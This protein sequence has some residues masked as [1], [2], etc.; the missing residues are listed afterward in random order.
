VNFV[1]YSTL[2]VRIF[3]NHFLTYI[4]LFSSLSICLTGCSDNAKLPSAKELAEFE[5]AGPSNGVIERNPYRV[6]ANEV[7]ELTMPAILQIVTA[8]DLGES[9]PISQYKCRISEKGTITLPVAGEIEVAGKTLAEIES[10]I[11][12]AYYPKY[13]LERPNIFV[14]LEERLEEPLFSV[15]GLV[16]KQGN[17]PYPSDSQYNLI[18]AIGFAGGLDRIAEPRF[19]T[20]YRLK[21]DGTVAKA[22]F[23]IVNTGEESM[24]KEAL[25][26]PIKPG[27]IID[28]EHTPRTRTN[29][30]LNG[31][32]RINIGTYIRFN[33]IWED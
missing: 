14:R 31:L 10:L 6:A 25:N 5:N 15:L 21:Q 9:G 24:L 11:I 22:V 18:Q 13:T 17:F 33:E 23:Q 19:A 12:D 20:I 30:F 26:I 28:V 3:K 27:D 1:K 16:N 32:F 29:A 2:S 8:E 7:L 4:F